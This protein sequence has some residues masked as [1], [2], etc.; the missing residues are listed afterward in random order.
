MSGFSVVVVPCAVLA[1]IATCSPPPPTT[2]PGPAA[3]YAQPARD[4]RAVARSVVI[5]ARD[6]QGVPRLIRAVA[7]RPA[8]AGATPEGAA[9]AH[10]AA[11]APLWIDG[12]R[13][14]DLATRGVQKL[15]NGAAIVRLQ[16]QVEQVDVYQGE[17]RVMVQPDGTLAAVSGT[18]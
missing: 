10:V 6:E 12:G 5:D 9:R 17:L 3:T 1:L 15:R 16:Q 8:P 4:L 2:T 13:A 11:L 7:P 14:A 18:L